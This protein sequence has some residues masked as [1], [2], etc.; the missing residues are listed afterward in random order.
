MS[1][2][3]LFASGHRP[4]SLDDDFRP[5]VL[6]LE[7][8]YLHTTNENWLRTGTTPHDELWEVDWAKRSWQPRIT[9]PAPPAVIIHDEWEGEPPKDVAGMISGGLLLTLVGYLFWAL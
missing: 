1:N 9:E 7:H 6:G 5:D 2:D 8:A 3:N 4:G